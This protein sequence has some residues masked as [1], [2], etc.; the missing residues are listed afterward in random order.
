MLTTFQDL[1]TAARQQPEPQRLLFTFAKV[2]LPAA[3][4]DAQR[5][6]F[7]AKD[8]GTLSP[9]MCVDKAPDEVES[10]HALVAESENTG[11]AWDIVFV[12]SMSGHA[13]I[14]PSADEAA[15][16][17]RFMVNA[18][19]NGRVADFAAFDRAGNVLQF[20]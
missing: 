16:P 15:Q 3:A 19:N 13:G 7:D 18:I 14:A 17:L 9:S 6:R 5:A 8:G 11:L 1:L 20:G 12:A 4:T 2:E 10:F